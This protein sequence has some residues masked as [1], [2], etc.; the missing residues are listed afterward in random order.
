MLRTE[1]TDMTP[2]AV[3]AWALAVGASG[4][5]VLVSDD[6]ALLDEPARALLAEVVAVGREVDVAATRGAAPSCPDLLLDA[7]LS[8]MLAGPYRL[9]GD[10]T[11]GT[12][13][14]RQL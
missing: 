3:R 8:T 5:M 9:T 11:V 13:E 14:L 7:P 1:A 10:P 6:L 2:E 4:G 12:A